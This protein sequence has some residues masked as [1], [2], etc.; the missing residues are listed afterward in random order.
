MT[1]R[2]AGDPGDDGPETSSPASGSSGSTGS[3]APGARSS[4]RRARRAVRPATNPGTDDAPDLATPR[5]DPGP[6]HS[7]HDRWLREQRPPHWE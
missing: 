4:R 7:P 6:G 5:E 3:D 1:D 2:P